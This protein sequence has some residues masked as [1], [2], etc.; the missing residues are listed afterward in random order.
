[1]KYSMSLRE[2][3]RAKPQGFPEG[4]GYI[5]SYIPIQVTIHTFS[6]TTP[7]LPFLDI[8][9]GRVDSLYCSDSWAIQENIAQVD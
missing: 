5:S 8:N 3:L 7:A 1:M 4:S 9:I 2:I 6:I